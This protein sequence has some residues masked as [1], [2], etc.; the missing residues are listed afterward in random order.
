MVAASRVPAPV[1]PSP[2]CVRWRSEELSAHIAAGLPER[3][4]WEAKQL[5]AVQEKH[6]ATR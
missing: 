6:S 4:I 2:G 3:S 1:R 5:K